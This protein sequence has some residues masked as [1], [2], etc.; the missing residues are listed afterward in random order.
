MYLYHLVVYLLEGERLYVIFGVFRRDEFVEMNN[1]VRY[2]FLVCLLSLPLLSKN[3]ST[4]G[5]ASIC[6]RLLAAIM[7]VAFAAPT[8]IKLMTRG[9][10]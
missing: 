4:L 8:V 5:K 2:E 7:V 1:E 9:G 10:N 6:L 3:T